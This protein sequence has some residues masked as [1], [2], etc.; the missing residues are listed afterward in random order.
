MDM[1]DSMITP[2]LTRVTVTLPESIVRQVDARTRNRSRF[3]LAAVEHELR[4][5]ERAELR[6]SLANPHPESHELAEMGLQD[7]A[8]ALPDENISTLIDLQGGQT[9][10]W[11]PGRGWTPA[12]PPRS[13]RPPRSR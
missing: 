12:R 11:E 1:I 8:D 9:V 4:R 3:I 5:V 7:W 10:H 13:H 2:H 6:R